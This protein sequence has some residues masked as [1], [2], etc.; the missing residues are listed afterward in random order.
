MSVTTA[1]TVPVAVVPPPAPATGE[2]APMPVRDAEGTAA[3]TP[4]DAP[5]STEAPANAP[6]PAEAPAAWP[7][8]EDA[9]R[10]MFRLVAGSCVASIVAGFA[11]SGPGEVARGTLTILTSPSG[12]LTDYIAVA[13]LGATLVNAGSLTLLSALLARRLGVLYNG[14]V[15]AA[16]LTVFGFALFGKNL[17]NSVPIMLGTF[18]YTRLDGSRFRTHLATSLFATA[19]APAVSW[20]AFGKGLPVWL[21]LALG[22]A[23]GILIGG[24]VP[25]LAAHFVTFHRGLSLYNIGFTAG[26]VGMVAVA[27]YNAFGFEVTEVHAISSGYTWWLA[28]GTAAFCLVLIA[29]GFHLNGRSLR[30]AMAFLRHPGRKSDF[31]A[32]EGAG[33]TQMNMGVMGL[34]GVAYVLAVGGELTGPS[35]GGVFTIIGFG[36]FGKHARNTV[37]VLAGVTLAALV[38]GSDLGS[39]GVVLTA[40]FGTTLA[41]LSGV[42]GPAAGVL[43]GFLHLAL[44]QNVGFLH[45]G[46]NL[47]NNGFA[48]GFV[49]LVLIPCLNALLR[50]RGKEPRAVD[51]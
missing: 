5:T 4:V 11:I 24:I 22:A 40:L 47:Y 14:P 9:S 23:A 37:P 35:L 7:R 3:P 50:I 19:L 48:A 39:T 44:V 45:S 12:L 32:L 33:R 25:P 38:T 41:P 20:L 27:I 49:A 28:G 8:I 18:L 36:A 21:G 2:H 29:N 34:I 43:A 15:V 30:G 1:P 10:S 13:S 16:L 26:I 6:S 31:L 51:V 42:Y 17:L 46:L